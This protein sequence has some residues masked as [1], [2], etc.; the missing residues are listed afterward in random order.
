MIYLTMKIKLTYEKTNTNKMK[1]QLLHE[2]IK[3]KLATR[4]NEELISDAKVARA[5][6]ADETQRMIFALIM[7]VLLTRISEIE[8]AQKV[9]EEMKKSSCIKTKIVKLDPYQE[10]ALK[11]IDAMK[12]EMVNMVRKKRDSGKDSF[13]LIPEKANKLHD[14]R[15]YC[16]ALCAWFLSEK[17]AERIRNKKRKFDYKLIDMLPV[18]PRKQV[19]KMFA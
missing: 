17:R 9:E 4:T 16:M 18:T 14:D 10:I 6:K 11:N 7:D 3:A 8:F 1:T 12:E 2:T 15:S 13:D 5:N 19:E